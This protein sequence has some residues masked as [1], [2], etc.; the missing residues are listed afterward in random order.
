[1]VNWYPL[2]APTSSLPYCHWATG[3]LLLP[4]WTGIIQADFRLL[5]WVSQYISVSL[6]FYICEMGC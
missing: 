5:L 4:P 1:M 3:F 2:P 6:T